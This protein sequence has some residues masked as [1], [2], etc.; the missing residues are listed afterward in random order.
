MKL[1]TLN[2]H[3]IVEE[4]YENK[5]KI[6]TE[7]VSELQPDIIAMQEVNQTI[8]QN[9]VIDDRLFVP[10]QSTVPLKADNH[11]YVTAKVLSELG[12]NYYYTW[13]GIKRGY[14]KYD[15]GLAV[16]SLKP[17]KNIKV[18]NLSDC[19]SYLDWKTRKALVLESSGVVICNTHMG[20]WEDKREPFINQ[21]K[22]LNKSLSKY[23]KVY[24]MGD[25]NSPQ[26]QRDAGYDKVLSDGW[27]DTYT[28][29]LFKDDGYTVTKKID[30]W[31]NHEKK[32]ID[33]IFTNFEPSVKSSYVVFNGKNK[34]MVSDHSGIILTL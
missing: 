24:L 23:N 2:T 34:E 19:N 13:A 7:A 27:H 6:F 10:C 25:F 32:R 15:E 1:L 3:S 21:W 12:L 22:R 9:E 8:N 4:D 18:I 31:K 29:A 11:A 14:N 20:W 28:Y 33:Y 26:D 16:M 5:L 17:I 30:G